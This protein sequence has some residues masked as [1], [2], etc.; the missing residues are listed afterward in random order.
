MYN[1]GLIEKLKLLIHQKD[2]L[3]RKG[4]Q[5]FPAF[6]SITTQLL[7]IYLCFSTRNGIQQDIKVI[8]Q[9]NLSQNV[10]ALI[11]MIKKTQIETIIID[12]NKVDL[13]M[14]FSRGVKYFKAISYISI[15]SYDVIESQSQLQNL[16]APLLHINCPNQLQCPKRISLPD[17]PFVNE[18]RISILNAVQ[19]LTQNINAYCSSLNQNHKVV[20]HIGQFL[21]NFTKDL[22]SMLFHDGKFSNSITTPASSSAEECQLSIIFLDNLLQM[23]TDRIKELSIVPKVFVALLNLVIFNESEQQCAEIVQRAVDIRS[24]SLSSLYHILTYGN[25]QIRKHIICDLKYYH[26]LV[27]VIGIGGACQEENDIVIHQGIISFYLILQYFRL[28]DSYN[29]FPSQLDLVKVV[30]EQIE[31]EGADEEIET[32]IFNLNYCPYYEMTN[33]FYFK[34]NHKNQYLDWSNYEDIEEDIEDD[35]D[36][37]P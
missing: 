14:A 2:S 16:V 37:P 30:E 26:T 3:D 20:V 5:S 19:H 10:S 11:E 34:I 8:I 21:V 32:H 17:S 6:S 24:K 15:D 12:K 29:R 18:F 22:N 35:R 9:N 27:G 36:N 4:I 13:E 31:Q 33:K 7:Q 28:G 25:A 23:N 1:S